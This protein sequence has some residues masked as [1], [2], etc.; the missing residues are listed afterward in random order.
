MGFSK[1]FCYQHSL[2]GL[3]H[4]ESTLWK[5]NPQK[6]VEDTWIPSN[7]GVSIRE[8]GLKVSIVSI[9]LL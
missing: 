3:N 5:Q 6:M 8:S 1:E 4:C 7:K 9:P 2:I